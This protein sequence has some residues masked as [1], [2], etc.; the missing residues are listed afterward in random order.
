[1]ADDFACC[2]ICMDDYDLDK[3][4]PKSLDCRHS[5]CKSCLLNKGR[6]LRRCPSCR[7]NIDKPRNAANDLTMIDYLE[8]KQQKRREGEQTK[9]REGLRN[10]LETISKELRAAEGVDEDQKRSTVK[11]TR[12]KKKSFCANAIGVVNKTST[13][14]NENKQAMSKMASVNRE[15]PDARIQSLHEKKGLIMSMLQQSYIN[16]EE[17]NRCKSET[18]KIIQ[19]KATHFNDSVENMWNVYRDCPLNDYVEAATQTPSNEKVCPIGCLQNR[20]FV[21]SCWCYYGQ[22]CRRKALSLTIVKCM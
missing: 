19:S 17:F 6:P 5:L 4:L 10:L 7:Q 13:P 12:K 16:Q 3:R 2:P 20:V 21:C 18:H 22:I 11:L 15:Q 8:R 9:L 1:M 14:Q